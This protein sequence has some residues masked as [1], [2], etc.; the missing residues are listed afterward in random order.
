MGQAQFRRTRRTEFCVLRIVARKEYRAVQV[1]GN[2]GS[3]NQ[4]RHH[5]AGQPGPHP[6]HDTYRTLWQ[7]AFPRFSCYVTPLANRLMHLERDDRQFP[8]LTRE[9]CAT[10]AA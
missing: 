1:R 2:N 8:V 10:L 6:F 9:F 4:G 3:A 5:P 7:P